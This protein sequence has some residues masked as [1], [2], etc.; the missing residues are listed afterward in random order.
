MFDL[1]TFPF[2]FIIYIYILE[3]VPGLWPD[4]NNFSNTNEWNWKW[5]DRS[6]L[7][8][9]ELSFFISGIGTN[10][11]YSFIHFNIF[12]VYIVRAHKYSSQDECLFYA[13]VT[14]VQTTTWPLAKY[15]LVKTP[16]SGIR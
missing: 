11:K 13:R 8:L 9:K 1:S 4:K 6:K 2:I 16:V 14:S 7:N 5:K 12:F 3:E 10:E 15:V